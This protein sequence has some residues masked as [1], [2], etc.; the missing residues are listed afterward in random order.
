MKVCLD[1]CRYLSLMLWCFFLCFLI[2]CASFNAKSPEGFAAYRENG[3]DKF[4]AISSDGVLYRVSAYEQKAEAS[5][6][7]WKEAFLLNMKNTN[8]KQEDS[9]NV[10]ISGKAAMG[11]IFS[12][13][14]NLGSDLYLVAA[15]PNGNKM[16]VVEATAER[17][18]FNARK[19]DILKA[20]G[21]I[22]L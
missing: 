13:A 20:I 14:N 4:K 10:S 6:D 22:E 5:M 17:E 1:N 21:E 8:Y 15:V 2:S 3:S 18:K 7:F 16:L 12:F 11:Y 19:A 9:L